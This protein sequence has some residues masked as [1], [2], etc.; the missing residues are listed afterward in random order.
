MS[1]DGVADLSFQRAD[2]FSLR[3]ALGDFA[4][5]VDP[6]LGAGVAH[7][8]NPTMWIAWFS[9]RFPRVETRCTMRPPEENSAGAV[10]L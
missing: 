4:V 6:A 8:A 1:V 10:L 7:L 9:C 5:D 2:R 3:L